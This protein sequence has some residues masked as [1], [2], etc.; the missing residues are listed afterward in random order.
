MFR[1]F[2]TGEIILILVVVMLLFG[3]KRMPD[4]ARSLGR[5]L[6][7]FKSET[8][9]LRDDDQT[10]RTGTIVQEPRQIDATSPDA[11]QVRPTAPE[12]ERTER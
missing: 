8:K 3:A 1:N 2:G 7:I 10:P 9:A 6:R 4:A 5:S 11:S 12:T